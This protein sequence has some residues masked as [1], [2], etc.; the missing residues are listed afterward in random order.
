MARTPTWDHRQYQYLDEDDYRKFCAVC[1]RWRKRNPPEYSS[2]PIRMCPRDSI[3]YSEMLPGLCRGQRN[4]MLIFGYT[5]EEVY[6]MPSRECRTWDDMT[7]EELRQG[8]DSWN[9]TS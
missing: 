6:E 4:A 2:K 5:C 9:E 7:D 3:N 1:V 8:R